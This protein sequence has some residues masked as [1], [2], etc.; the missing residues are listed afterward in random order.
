MVTQEMVNKLESCFS[1]ADEMRQFFHSL[2]ELIS[3]LTF[4]FQMRKRLDDEAAALILVKELCWFTLFCRENLELIH[5][6][7]AN[8]DYKELTEEEAK[9]LKDQG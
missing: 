8:I 3:E 9:R 6:L 2:E 1:D 4:S 5:Q 7:I